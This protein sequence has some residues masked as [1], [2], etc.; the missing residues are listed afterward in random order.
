MSDKSGI[1]QNMFYY[2][3]LSTII[4][5]INAIHSPCVDYVTEWYLLALLYIRQTTSF[6]T[7]DNQNNILWISVRIKC[8]KK[9]STLG[10]WAKFS[11]SKTL[12]TAN[13]HTLKMFHSVQQ[14]CSTLMLFYSVAQKYVHWCH[15]TQYFICIIRT[16][17]KHTLSPET[18]LEFSCHQQKLMKEFLR[19]TF[20]LHSW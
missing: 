3:S 20:Y 16:L 9:I 4:K 15:L 5:W 8:Y 11:S 19:R 7:I 2:N 14:L 10:T 6:L 17:T 12:Y 18:T 1:T 13:M